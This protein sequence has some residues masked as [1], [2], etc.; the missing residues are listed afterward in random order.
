MRN[1]GCEWVPHRL[2][3]LRGERSLFLH[4]LGP[5]QMGLRQYQCGF[6]NLKTRN[7]GRLEQATMVGVCKKLVPPAR[8]WRTH[9]ARRRTRIAW[10]GSSKER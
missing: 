1:L 10:S 5:L 2:A 3:E 6:S 7:L 9:R 8:S 4:A